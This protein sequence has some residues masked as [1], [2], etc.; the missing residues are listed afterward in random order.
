VPLW[1]GDQAGPYQTV[2]Y[3]GHHWSPVGNPSRYPH[4]YER[5][6]IAKLLTLFH[7]ASG[8][9]RVEGVVQTTNAILHPWMMTQLEA[10]LAELPEPSIALDPVANRRCWERWQEGLSNPLGLPDDLPPLRMLLVLDNLQ[11]HH[12]PS[13]VLWLIEHGIMP[14]YTPIGGSWLNMT[15]S[16]QGILAGRALDGQHPESA[17]E[18]IEWLEA[19]ARGWNR[20]PTPFVWGGKRRTRRSRAHDRRHA[21]RGSGACTERPIP[22]CQAA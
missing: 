7:P 19:T 22:K 14:L 21:L 12:T 11:G 2:P 8:R 6:G 16:I 5:N 1:A 18:I 10:I 13:F 17:E 3:P 9:V 15:E 4:E 20:D